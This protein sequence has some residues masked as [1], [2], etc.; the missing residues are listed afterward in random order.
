M[1][2]DF[3]VDA[4]TESLH[5][6]PSPDRPRGARVAALGESEATK[7]HSRP[8]LRVADNWR[9]RFQRRLIVSD[10]LA[11]VWVVFGT[12]IAWFGF[13]NAQ[14]AIAKDARISDISYWLFSI[15]LIVAW[16][17]ALSWSDSRSYRVIGIGTTEY[18]R[19]ASSS[20]RLFGVIAIIAFLTQT[21]VARGFLLLSLP[22][23]VVI[24]LWTRW[25]WRHWLLS[26]RGRGEWSARLLLVGSESSVSQIARELQRS[27]RSGYV[28]VGACI[29]HGKIADTIE[30]TD[31]PVMG[32]VNAVSSAMAVV[33]ADTVAITSTDELPADKVKEISWHLEAGRQHM[34]LAPS[35]IDI[36]GPRL[37]TRPVAGLPLIHVETPR[38]SMG[39][40]FVKRTFDLICASIFI[41]L[42]S[43]LL[44]AVTIAVSWTSTGPLLYKQVRI[45]RNGQPFKMLKFR[46]MRVGADKELKALLEA[47]GT[48][49]KPLFKIK[50]DPRI[51]PVGTFIRKYSLDEL[52]QLFN[53]LGGSMSLVGPRPQIAAEVALYTDAARRRLLARPGLTGLWQVSGRSSLDWEDAVR[54]DLY[55]VENWSLVSDLAILMKT[56]KAVLAPGESAH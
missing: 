45:G 15:I 20:F 18:V 23:G 51:T 2:T 33:R 27:P 21:D 1:S 7:T 12:Q 31:V 17:G 30:G 55:Y 49:E 53:V 5:N 4:T 52:P 35:I 29:P 42:L 41:V 36:A 26:K 32:S 10:L 50:D 40:R 39:Q 19:V 46:S 22:I 9:R 56:A 24:L 11:L 43:P 13:G 14:L 37:H 47:Q 28:V 54:L 44:L 8:A 38:F 25:L 3:E 48:S 6:S 16:M 34:V